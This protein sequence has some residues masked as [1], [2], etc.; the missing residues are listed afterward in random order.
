MA[1]T[2][3]RRDPRALKTLDS[4]LDEEGIREE[5]TV[6]ALKRVIAFALREAMQSHGLTKAAMADQMKTTRKQV[7]RVLDPDEHNITLDTLARAANSVGK[8][9]KVELV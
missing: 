6:V 9:L 4:W 3:D 1:E 2:R 5:V 8:Q 7:D